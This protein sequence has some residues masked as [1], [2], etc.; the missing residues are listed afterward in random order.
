MD[1]A[2]GGPPGPPP[3]ETLEAAERGHILKALEACRWRVSGKGGAAE[4]LGLRPSTLDFRIKKLG[5][6][7]PA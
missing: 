5:I 3:I 6:N 1:P 4:L 2:P 7:R